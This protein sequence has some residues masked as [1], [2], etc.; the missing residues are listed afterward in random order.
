MGLA[1]I[2]DA[3]LNQ[4]IKSLFRFRKNSRHIELGAWGEQVVAKELKR[5]GFKILYRNYRGPH[6]GEIDLVC[7]DRETLVFVEVK[8]RSSEKYSRPL[9]AVNRKK[10]KLIQRGA[11]AW[12]R[13][14]GLPDLTFRFDVVEVIASK[15]PE[16]RLIENAFQMPG[17]FRY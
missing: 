10:Q 5:R 9:D 14:L 2:I 16:I 1:N 11:L 4:S 17:W 7:R 13:L 8:T 6:G 3:V 15:P 12:L